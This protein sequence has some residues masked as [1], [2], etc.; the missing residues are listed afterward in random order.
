MK[1][2]CWS[3]VKTH[4][5]ITLSVVVRQRTNRC[6]WHITENKKKTLLN[7]ANKI[8]RTGYTYNSKHGVASSQNIALCGQ[9]RNFNYILLFLIQL[10]E[11]RLII[12]FLHNELQEKLIKVSHEIF[13]SKIH[14]SD[15]NNTPVGPHP[16]PDESSPQNLTPFIIQFNT[17]R[18]RPVAKQR[19]RNERDSGRCGNGSTV[20]SGVFYVVTRPTG[21]S[22][23]S[24]VQSAGPV[25]EVL[26]VGWL[27]SEWVSK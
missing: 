25:S 7:T 21:F 19:P 14:Y 13:S 3:V 22:S 11:L 27:A 23:V 18:Y 2:G 26:R 6:R 10:S 15:R 5:T 24:A 17:V 8:V 12:F 1:A 16:V 4:S 9:T 20:G